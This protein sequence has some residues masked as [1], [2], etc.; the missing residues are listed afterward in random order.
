[1]TALKLTKNRP[2]GQFTSRLNCFPI[3]LPRGHFC[4]VLISDFR[5]T[6]NWYCFCLDNKKLEFEESFPWTAVSS[7]VNND[8]SW[9]NIIAQLIIK[10]PRQNYTAD[11]FLFDYCTKIVPKSFLIK[12]FCYLF[13]DNDRVV[14]LLIKLLLDRF[15]KNARI[16]LVQ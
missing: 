11:S 2:P 15:V 4:Q 8:Y 9:N 1:M 13:A 6:G 16:H 12:Y 7:F 5:W 14:A 3:V 10:K